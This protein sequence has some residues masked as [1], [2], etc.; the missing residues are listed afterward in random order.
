MPEVVHKRAE[1]EKVGKV[2]RRS[3]QY[4]PVRAA[5]SADSDDKNRYTQRRLV[6]VLILTLFKS[7]RDEKPQKFFEVS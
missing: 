7:K 4:V 5:G 6:Q 3:A 2:L 1:A